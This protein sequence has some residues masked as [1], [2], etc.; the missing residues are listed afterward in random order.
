M[1]TAKEKKAATKGEHLS[2]RVSAQSKFAVEFWSAIEGQS[3]TAFLQAAIDRHAEML[4]KERGRAWR[5]LFHPHRGVREIR[6]YLLS[7]FPLDDEQSRRRE[8]VMTHRAFF[9]VERDGKL[10][11]NAAFIET[12]WDPKKRLDEFMEL[13]PGNYW[14]PGKV[15]G[16]RLKARGFDAPVWPPP[17]DAAP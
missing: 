16:K 14:Q 2:Q 10:E 11:A 8:F 6:L 5:G 12:L 15:M 17:K 3:E 7:S 4:S 9:L 13:W 1:V